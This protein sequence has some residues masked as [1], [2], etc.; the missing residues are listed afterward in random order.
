MREKDVKLLEYVVLPAL[1]GLFV[2]WVLSGLLR[3]RE[4]NA[5]LVRTVREAIEMARGAHQEAQFARKSASVFRLL[6]MVV[7]A[8]GPLIVAY[9][10][11]RIQ[12]RSDT[13]PEQ[14]LQL[15]QDENLINLTGDKRVEL[16]QPR[17]H[18]LEKPSER[19]E[20]SEA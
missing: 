19:Q 5:D 8:A 15:L 14:M 12:S 6:A 4:P 16:P 1:L 2:L 9:L 3:P 17:T 11:F 7:G 18:V 20:D 13:T 10:I